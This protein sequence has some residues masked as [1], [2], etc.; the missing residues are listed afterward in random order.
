MSRSITEH[1]LFKPRASKAETKA[2]ITD[3]GAR[4]II[5][6]EAARR[7]AKTAKLRQA[8]L[9]NEAK[10]VTVPAPAKLR[11]KKAASA[12]QERFSA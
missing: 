9:E 4:A 12:R 7:E 11:L 6:D 3:H 2:G 8:R 10:Q 1:A 5:G